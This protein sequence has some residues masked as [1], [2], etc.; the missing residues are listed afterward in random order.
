MKTG[1]PDHPK[2]THL[3]VLLKVPPYSAWGLVEGLIH[4]TR[5]FAPRGNIGR[6]SDDQ[7][8]QLLRWD[9]K[10]SDLVK[11]LADA[12]WLDAHKKHR[13]VVHDWPD[14]CEDAVHMRLAR[15]NERFADGTIPK[16]TRLT[17]DERA[18]ISAKYEQ[19][20]RKPR[21]HAKRTAN[22]QETHAKRTTRPDQTR[23]MPSH[24]LAQPEPRAAE[25]SPE[26]GADSAAPPPG[27]V[28]GQ[29]PAEML[30]AIPIR[31]PARSFLVASGV[32]CETIA[33]VWL[34]VKREQ[35]TGGG[36]TN[37][38][39]VFITRVCSVLGV[40]PPSRTAPM[41]AAVNGVT[42]GQ[43]ERM[44]KLRQTRSG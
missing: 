10:P 26:P 25:P 18:E 23:A 36:I 4:A 11:A 5:A 29:T 28:A 38:Q 43:I 19:K 7:I 42:P 30:A 14:H 9:G 13:W 31:E 37:A 3:A 20:Q 21:A 16:L 40:K 39:A 2:M 12:R 44:S 27:W 34:G 6:F 15:A 33:A 1:A 24:A 22:A 8:A 17:A 32:T 41:R 35:L